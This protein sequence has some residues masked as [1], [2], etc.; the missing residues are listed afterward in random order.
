MKIKHAQI[1]FVI[2]TVAAVAGIYVKFRGPSAALPAEYTHTS[3]ENLIS[4]S[5]GTDTLPQGGLLE[6]HITV[7]SEEIITSF[8]EERFREEEIDLMARVVQAEYGNGDDTDKRLIVSVILNRLEDP[9]FPGTIHGVITQPNQFAISE[10]ASVE[11]FSSVYKEV[12]DRTDR[13][14]LWFRAGEYPKY[15]VP[16]YE[17]NNHYF[18]RKK[19]EGER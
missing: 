10:W 4:P 6:A 1:A 8:E 5:K 12:K 3:S 16:A 19:R 9:D 11:C 17:R 18:T 2:V 14:I 15:G 13:E 7:H